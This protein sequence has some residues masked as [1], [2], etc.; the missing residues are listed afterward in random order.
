MVE[1]LM[2]LSVLEWL[3]LT[4]FSMIPT[5]IRTCRRLYGEPNTQKTL[6]GEVP[7]F[8]EAMEELD[9][10]DGTAQPEIVEVPDGFYT[11]KIVLTKP[12]EAE[13]IYELGS[14]SPVG[15]VE[16]ETNPSQ[17]RVL[18][19]DVSECRIPKSRTEIQWR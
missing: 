12:V 18:E 17:V 10:L 1:M 3:W 7:F 8:Q 14:A 6:V 16:Y 13:W 2:D 11:K 5:W 19:Y 9:R 15:F 4:L